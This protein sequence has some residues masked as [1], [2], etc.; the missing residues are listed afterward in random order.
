MSYEKKMLA[1]WSCR[2]W[3]KNLFHFSP[4]NNEGEKTKARTKMGKKGKR[5]DFEAQSYINQENINFKMHKQSL[6]R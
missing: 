1:I 4:S 6:Q 5:I 2:I 3:K